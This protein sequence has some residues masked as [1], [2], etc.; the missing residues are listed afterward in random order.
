VKSLR[1]GIRRLQVDSTTRA[2]PIRGTSFPPTPP[3]SFSTS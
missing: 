1:D 3:D 2:V